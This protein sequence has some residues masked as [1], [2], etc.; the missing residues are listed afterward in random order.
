MRKTGYSKNRKMNLS[1]LVMCLV[2]VAAFGFL[3]TFMGQNSV[4]TAQDAHFDSP[5][6]ELSN[7]LVKLDIIS[8][9]DLDGISL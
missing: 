8:Q 5:L 9:Q 4:R 6:N 3:N 1:R 7:E 2:L